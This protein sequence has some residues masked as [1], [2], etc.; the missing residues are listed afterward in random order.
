V[1]HRFTRIAAEQMDAPL[2]YYRDLPYAARGEWVPADIGIPEGIETRWPLSVGEID[3]WAS[4]VALYQ[5]QLS[6]LWV[7]IESMHKELRDDHDSMGGIWLLK[8]VMV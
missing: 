2:W 7:D 3:A 8:H 1:D 4:A 5:S 6:G